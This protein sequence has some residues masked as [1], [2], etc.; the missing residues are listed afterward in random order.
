MK[1]VIFLILLLFGI[2]PVI[3]NAKSLNDYYNELAKNDVH[4]LV[5]KDSYFMPLLPFFVQHFKEVTVIDVRYHESISMTKV[6]DENDFD[7]MMLFFHDNNLQGGSY[8][9]EK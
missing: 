8:L 2:F 5:L 7:M 4:L 9:F 1:K 6:I 3:V